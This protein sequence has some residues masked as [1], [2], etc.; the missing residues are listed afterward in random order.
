M[1]LAIE[2]GDANTREEAIF[3]WAMDYKKDCEQKIMD[4]VPDGRCAHA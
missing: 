1:E 2:R 3:M 4:D